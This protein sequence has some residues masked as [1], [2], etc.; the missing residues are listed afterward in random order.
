VFVDHTTSGGFEGCRQRPC[1]LDHVVVHDRFK[2]RRS[3]SRDERRHQK[4]ELRLA[5]VEILQGLHEEAYILTLLPD[6][7]RWWVLARGGEVRAVG[8]ASN[9]DQALRAAAD[10]ADLVIQCGAGAAASPLAADRAGHALIVSGWQVLVGPVREMRRSMSKMC[11]HLAGSCRLIVTPSGQSGRDEGRTV[12]TFSASK[13]A[14]GFEQ[15]V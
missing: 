9:L 7:D 11:H 6:G 5:C 3:V 15:A 14:S 4:E 10:R 1:S 2:L 13:Q 8:R 12:L